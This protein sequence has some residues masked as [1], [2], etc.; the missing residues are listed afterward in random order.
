MST[1]Q[2]MDITAKVV[3]EFL[4]A[5]KAEEEKLAEDQDENKE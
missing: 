2:K 3:A 4:A 5:V 1:Q